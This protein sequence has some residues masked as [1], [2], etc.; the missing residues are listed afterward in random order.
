MSSGHSL[1][2]IHWL[3]IENQN[4]GVDRYPLKL[5][6]LSAVNL[7]EELGNSV[8]EVLNTRSRTGFRTI[9][10][11]FKA[12]L[13]GGLEATNQGAKKKYTLKDA[14]SIID[15]IGIA[16]AGIELGS[17]IKKAFPSSEVTEEEVQAFIENQ[18]QGQE[19]PEEGN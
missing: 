18:G 16:K 6:T 8:L 5:T 15:Q 11:M 1:E 4:G 17:V 2:S 3:E 19:G 9:A 13:N 12:S 7:E 10:L 14:C